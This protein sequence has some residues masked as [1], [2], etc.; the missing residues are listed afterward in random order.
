[1][2]ISLVKTSLSIAALSLASSLASAGIMTLTGTIYDK[3]AAEPDFQDGISGVKTGLVSTMLNGSGVPDYIGPG[4]NTAASGNIQSAASFSNWWKDTNGTK[5]FSLDLT[6]TAT[7]GVFNYSNSAFFPID[8]QLAG[9]EGNSHNYHF[10]M[11]LQ[12]K[13]T[14]K[15]TDAFSFTGDDDLWVYINNKLVMD[16]G[17]VHGPASSSITGA[18]LAA[19]GLAEDTEYDLDIFFAERHLVLSN[20]NITTSFRVKECPPNDRQCNPPPPPPVEVPE[21]ASLALLG[22]GLLGLGAARRR[23][24]R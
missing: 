19:L 5:A 6:E 20:F 21:P 18:D 11:H 14:F 17:G 16:I 24:N 9:N 13:T 2:K 3:I 4:G 10:T 23:I 7:P 15:T 22:I 12:G 8:G 1:M